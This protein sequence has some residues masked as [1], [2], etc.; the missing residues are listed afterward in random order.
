MKSAQQHDPARP[1]ML[2]GFKADD[3]WADAL[4]AKA[5]AARKKQKLTRPKAAKVKAA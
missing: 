3:A 2:D 1:D 5:R 4:E